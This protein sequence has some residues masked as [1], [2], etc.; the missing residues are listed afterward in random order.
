MIEVDIGVHDNG[1][2][3][4]RLILH[5]ED[6]ECFLDHLKL[7]D[8][9]IVHATGQVLTDLRRLGFRRCLDV[10]PTARSIQEEL[11]WLALQDRW[12]SQGEGHY[13]EPF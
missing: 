12:R 4:A 1:M 3:Y 13:V 8:Y 10:S 6:T 5:D 7:R 2:A 9:E 11:D